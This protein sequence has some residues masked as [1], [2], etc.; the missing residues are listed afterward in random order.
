MKVEGKEL[1]AGTYALFPE[2]EKNGPWYW[3]FSSHLGWGSFQYD[4]QR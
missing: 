3:I 2:L 4:P 1:E